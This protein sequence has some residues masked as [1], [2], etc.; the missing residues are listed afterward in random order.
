MESIDQK[1]LRS[2]EKA[3]ILKLSD[4]T[5]EVWACRNGAGRYTAPDELC[6]IGIQKDDGHK[7]VM[8]TEW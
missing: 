3:V 8:I 5:E 2:E 7:R 4:I 1:G 6:E